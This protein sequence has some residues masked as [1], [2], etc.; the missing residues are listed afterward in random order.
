MGA[1]TGP[2][3]H[4]RAWPQCSVPCVLRSGRKQRELPSCPRDR[5]LVRV[6]DSPAWGQLLQLCDCDVV[7]L[8]DSRPRVSS[9]V[10]VTS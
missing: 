8:D 4:V 9:Y 1:E 5:D 2:R 10:T 6:T 3:A 7:G